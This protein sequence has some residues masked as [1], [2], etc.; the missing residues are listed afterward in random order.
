MST[1]GSFKPQNPKG[2]NG[3]GSSRPI[4]L[5][6]D[7]LT[8]LHC[9]QCAAGAFSIV[10]RFLEISS[11][12]HP[13]PDGKPQ[14]IRVDVAMCVNCGSIW[15]PSQLRRVDPKEREAL[16]AVLAAKMELQEMNKVDEPKEIPPETNLKPEDI[17]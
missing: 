1:K 2:L 3:R 8:S 7:D 12:I 14:I 9:P 13:T 6:P 10:Q 17:L 5:N 16:R 11:L 4:P 15:E